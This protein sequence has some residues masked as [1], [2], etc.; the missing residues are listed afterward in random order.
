M[1]DSDLNSFMKLSQLQELI[2]GESPSELEGGIQTGFRILS[3]IKKAFALAK[4][5]PEIAEWVKS[6]DK[7]QAQA[8]PQPSVVGVV[9]STGAG[10]SSVINAVLDEECLVPTNCMRACT[11]VITEIAYNESEQEDQKY[12]A[13]IHFISKD[14]WVKE[15]RVMLADMTDG[16]D[17]LG[18]EYTSGESEAAVAYHKMRAVYPF[19]E[20]EELRKG[21]FDIDEL[22]AEPSV[23]D[24]FGTVK[25]VTAPT[26]K[27]F[28]DLLKRFIDSKE[29][30]RGGKKEPS[31]LEYW[32]LIKVVKVFVRSSILE[33]GLV[34]VDLPGVHDSNAARSAVA[35]KYIERCSGLWV[36]APIARAVDD[37]VAQNLLGDTFRRQL[38]F[39]GNYSSITVICSKADDISVTEILKLLPEEAEAAQLHARTGLRET[40]R[41]KL[42]EKYDTVKK[43][44]SGIDGEIEQRQADI[45][46]LRSA[47]D[48]PSDEDDLILFS[49]GD[50][51]EKEHMSRE[52]A[53][54]QL[55]ETESRL[56]ELRT[57]RKELRQ[58]GS[59]TQK[60]LKEV[61]AE[62]R[63]LKS[64]TKQA[65]IK[66]RNGYSRPAIQTQFAEGVRELDQE[67]AADDEDNFDPDNV[68]RD[69]SDVAKKLLV[70]CV[71]SK[72]YQKVSG[73]LENDERISGFTH[74]EDTEIPALQ[75]HALGIVQETRTVTGRRFLSELS[76]FLTSL[77]LQVVQSGQPLKLA[78]NMRE[79]EL[80]SLAKAMDS[81]Q[82]ELVLTIRHS[83]VRSQE[84]IASYVSRKFKSA[85]REASAAAMPTVK[86]WICHRNNGG[87]AYETFRATCYRD[88]VFKGLKRSVDF[89]SA[90]AD[91]MTKRLARSWEYVFSSAFPHN[92]DVLAEAL[93]ES[94]RSFR[95]Q[96][97]QR[98]ELKK[99]PSLALVTRQVENLER[100]LKDAMEFKAM[101]SVR[102]KEASRLFIP[103][104]TS[105]MASA[106]AHCVRER[107]M[108]CFKR[109]KAHVVAHVDEARN[110]MFKAA[111][112][113]V[114]SALNDTLE[115]LEAEVVKKVEDVVGLVDNGY[116]S[117][118]I[119]QNIFRALS[120]SRDE[121]RNLL[122]QVDQQF[123]QVLRPVR[124]EDT[125]A[126][127]ADFE[128]S[129]TA[130]DP[131][132][133]LRISGSGCG[134]PVA[135]SAD[136]TSPGNSGG[137]VRIKK[138]PS[139]EVLAEDVRMRDA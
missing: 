20:S 82:L 72:A 7:L 33:S 59:S 70:F 3:S 53:R 138:E 6:C 137:N 58:L 43:G 5:V 51:P 121:V 133:P 114:E 25:Q 108:G 77:H 136:R 139:L 124:D 61:R 135:S 112:K 132:T 55:R 131:G 109:M 129:A 60:D 37:K 65:C 74:L 38:Q 1:D 134:T 18:T 4:T 127:D 104:V 125:T 91:P 130:P 57:A 87:L 49:P 86:S 24:L 41:D 46:N 34:L 69:Y 79:K 120:S 26:S 44:L 110:T 93:G 73:R 103:A 8:A 92:L 11:A 101:V 83:F 123:E 89:N 66:Y 107:G 48:D 23:K 30:A 42:Q 28:L 10:K 64:E 67:N 45:N 17:A 88:G 21:E 15:L 113:D 122:S 111:V 116:R 68:R 62:I 12:R 117:L 90:L 63:S 40:E 126:M 95:L 9:G 75:R 76:R 29:K 14:D 84:L 102:Q 31:D 56:A 27:D 19:L 80:Q 115:Q 97:D 13:E 100:D 54:R 22:V 94:L 98:P 36:V 106:Y 118:L 99:A 50:E 39:D 119:D 32:P 71:S 85:A 78:D 105:A 96:M 35:A 2:S 16:Q 128:A 47:L 81:L 52:Q